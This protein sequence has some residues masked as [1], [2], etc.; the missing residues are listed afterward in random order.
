MPMNLPEP[1][2][3]ALADI[4]RESLARHQPVSIPGL[5]TF[6]VEH[7]PSQ[8]MEEHGISV[9]LP[10]RDVVVFTQES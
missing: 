3:R 1:V 10:P 8:I 4:I 2:A 7:Q 5:G 9:V 6:A